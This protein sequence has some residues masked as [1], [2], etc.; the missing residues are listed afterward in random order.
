[1]RIATALAVEGSVSQSFEVV[2]DT[3]EK[4]FTR[5]G[6]LGGAC[7]AYYRREKVVD[8]WGGV[9]DKDTGEPWLTDT[10]VI[11]YSATKD[12][13]AMTLAM[14]HSR[15]WLDDKAPVAAYWPEFVQH[16]KDRL[17]V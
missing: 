4:N 12:L 10:M 9:R 16:G 13:A 15:R 17:T 3:F 6:E 7:C 2:R 14:A 11:V 8:L 1:M 5:P